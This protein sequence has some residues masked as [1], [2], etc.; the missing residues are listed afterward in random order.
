MISINYVFI[1]VILNFVLLL[2]VLNRLLYKP[3]KQFL[4]ERQQKIAADIDQAKEARDEAENLV[5]QKEEELR[6][7]AEEVRKMKN[8]ARR[9]AE[10]QAAEILKNAK[11]LEKKM[12]EDTESQ[13]EHEK[14]KAKKEIE[15]E[16]TGLVTDLSAKFLS[17]KIDGDNDRKL[18]GK[19]LAQPRKTAK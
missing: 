6:L 3:I 17:E 13:L 18:I 14:E 2:I 1:I 19:L 9:D 8:A 7:S 10:H 15:S 16:I 12:M 5:Q 4:T 11:I